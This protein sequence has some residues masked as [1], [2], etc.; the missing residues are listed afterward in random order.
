MLTSWFHLWAHGLLPLTSTN[1]SSTFQRYVW[2]KPGLPRPPILFPRAG[3]SK[4]YEAARENGALLQDSS[5][6]RT[7]EKPLGT[8]WQATFSPAKAKE[9]LVTTQPPFP[10]S[11]GIWS[12]KHTG[13]WNRNQR[14]LRAG[15]WGKHERWNRERNGRTGDKGR[16]ETEPG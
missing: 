10:W 5:G 11:S 8:Q 15:R 13:I 1:I 12:L 6:S 2:P 4:V 7:K 9:P 16:K 14:F 3:G